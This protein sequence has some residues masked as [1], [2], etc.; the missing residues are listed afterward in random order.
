MVCHLQTAKRL[1]AI[2]LAEDRLPCQWLCFV[3]QS[4]D[5]VCFVSV[6]ICNQTNDLREVLKNAVLCFDFLVQKWEVLFWSYAVTI[7]YLTSE[8]IQLLGRFSGLPAGCIRIEKKSGCI[9]SETIFTYF[10]RNHSHRVFN[11]SGI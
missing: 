11:S 7:P 2:E 6:F 1:E 3:W 5:R 8:L 10:H 4:A 9:R